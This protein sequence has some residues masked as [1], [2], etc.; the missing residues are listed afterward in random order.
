MARTGKGVLV[1]GDLNVAHA[2]MDLANPQSNVRNAGFT[3][4][5]RR[6]FSALVGPP[7][8]GIDDSPGGGGG[9]SRARGAGAKGVRPPRGAA[10][11]RREGAAASATAPT[12]T[13]PTVDAAAAPLATGA[14][15]IAP[16]PAPRASP[17]PP[18]PLMVDTLRVAHP[19]TVVYTFWSSRRGGEARAKNVG[20]RLDYVLA[21]AAAAGRVVAAWAR[22]EVGGSDHAPVGV[23]IRAA[24]TPPPPAAG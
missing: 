16:L 4:A 9:P 14:S 10:G 13:A 2:A 1:A 11:R 18:P 17:P 6:S 21:S 19:T 23:T 3:P 22:P 5:E 12:A 20:W 15:A 7:P 24:L 8:G